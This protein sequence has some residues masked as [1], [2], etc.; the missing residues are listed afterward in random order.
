MFR[1]AIDARASRKRAIAR[2]ERAEADEVV[3]RQLRLCENLRIV[4]HGPV[5]RERRDDGVDAR[6]V[7]EARVDHRR[8]L[9]DAA[10]ERR[11]DALDGGAQR[12]LREKRAP[13]S[14]SRPLRST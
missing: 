13:V 2:V 6:A 1:R 7:L 3:E 10:A 12:V 5:E 4:R 11:D 14:S 9:V 8:R